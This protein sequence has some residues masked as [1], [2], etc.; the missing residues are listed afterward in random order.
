MKPVNFED[1]IC[2]ALTF[3]DTVYVVS[4]PSCKLIKMEAHAFSLY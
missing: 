2:D 3:G 1:K 4:D